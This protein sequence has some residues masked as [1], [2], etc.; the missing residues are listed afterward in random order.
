MIGSFR[1]ELKSAK[2]PERGK[3]LKLQKSN[4]EED[5]QLRRYRRFAVGSVRAVFVEVQLIRNRSLLP[6]MSTIS[7]P[8]TSGVLVIQEPGQK[9]ENSRPECH[10]SQREHR[11][12]LSSL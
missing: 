3:P 8:A 2:Q 10:V 5:K 11:L 9:I 7:Q 12:A 4:C 1:F 6:H